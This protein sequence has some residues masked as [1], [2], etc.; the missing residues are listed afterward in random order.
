MTFSLLIEKEGDCSKLA[1]RLKSVLVGFKKYQGEG[2]PN[3]TIEC[4]S[5]AISDLE[6]CETVFEE[7]K[8]AP[9]KGGKLF[10]GIENEI[11]R[12]IMNALAWSLEIGKKKNK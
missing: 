12:T 6:H 1:K 11:N 10:Q 8:K 4:M 2:G 5:D 7:I 9:G 3:H